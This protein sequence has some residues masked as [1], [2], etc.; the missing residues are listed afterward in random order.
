MSMSTDS[1]FWLFLMHIH[2]V[3]YLQLPYWEPPGTQWVA[4]IHTPSPEPSGS[5]G[6]PPFHDVHAAAEQQYASPVETAASTD[7]PTSPLCELP[8]K[9]VCNHSMK[10]LPFPLWWK[11]QG[12]TT[13][14][15]S[16]ALSWSTR[17]LRL[18]FS[19]SS[20]AAASSFSLLRMWPMYSSLDAGLIRSK[21]SEGGPS[22]FSVSSSL[23]RGPVKV[24]MNVQVNHDLLI[25]WSFSASVTSHSYE[26]ID[27]W[28]E[29]KSECYCEFGNVSVLKTESQYLHK[30]GKMMGK[31]RKNKWNTIEFSPNWFWWR[32]CS[33]HS[34]IKYLGVSLHS[35]QGT[36]EWIRDRHR[37]G[38]WCY[39][40]EF[41]LSPQLQLVFSEPYAEQWLWLSCLKGAWECGLWQPCKN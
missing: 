3:Q 22:T 37:N 9:T 10:T 15:A 7:S 39:V 28:N 13:S 40:I 16:W 14:W 8:V 36:M 41:S 1:E 19:L 2:V 18:L 23:Q 27:I 29:R 17:T 38:R 34:L 33:L 32:K 35:L 20:R 30:W 11:R 12:M 24:L 25:V 26:T 6:S 31:R 21:G 4:W 5:V